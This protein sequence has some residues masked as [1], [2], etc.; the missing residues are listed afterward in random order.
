M[1]KRNS[2][3]NFVEIETKQQGQQ[4]QQ[5]QEGQEEQQKLIEYNTRT[6]QSYVSKGFEPPENF[7]HQ[8]RHFLSKIQYDP[9]G[10]HEPKITK[11]VTRIV[12][13][14]A[15]D[16]STPKKEIKEYVYW[17][18]NWYGV[19]WQGSK[20]A[21][22]ADHVEGVYEEV[23][24]ENVIKANKVIG[25]KMSGKHK[26]YYIPFSKEAVD[27]II[28]RSDSSYK[29]N[30]IYVVKNG[31]Y[32]NGQYSYD[33]FV[34]L[35]FDDCCRLMNMKGGPRLNPQVLEEALNNKNNK[36]NSNNSNEKRQ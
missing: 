16:Y 25:K 4:G 13:L 15:P 24:T 22:V 21:P 11:E 8:T 30:I 3:N 7:D 9:S 2:N 27:K 34:N 35:S 10:K 1:G 31:D 19:D 17:F 28:E 33:Q 32:R 18:E 36:N 26:S 29:E 6:Y 5:G 14:R 23:E 12:R 20:V